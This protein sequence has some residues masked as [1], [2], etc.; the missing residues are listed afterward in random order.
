M[1]R[2]LCP[3]IEVLEDRCVPSINLVEVEPNN[4][5]MTAN[6]MQ[7][8]L[9]THQIMS[10]RIDTLGDRDWFAIQL[11]RGDV[12][13]AAVNRQS[14]LDPAVRLVNA[15][16]TTLV[17]NDNSMLGERALPPESPL[18][19]NTAD[20]HDSEIYY[21]ISATGTYY[22]EVSAS[23]D[24]ST[25]KYNLDTVVA[26]PGLESQPVGTKQ[27]LYLDFD[28]ANVNMSQFADKAPGSIK[29]APLADSMTA[30]GLTIADENAYI[31]A[32]IAQVKADLSD[33]VRANGLN[34]DYDASG[35]PGEFAIDIRNSRDNPDPFGTNPFASRIVIG[36]A[37]NFPFPTGGEAQYIDVGNF[38]TNDEAVV[39]LNFTVAA[40][41][42]APATVFDYD[43]AG[44]AHLISH[45]AG[46]IFGCFHTEQSAD[47]IF[48]GTPNLMDHFT[49]A[50]LGPDQIFGTADDINPQFGVDNYN[51][52]YSGIDDTLNTVAFGLST[53]K[54]TVAASV[55]A[56]STASA[57]TRVTSSVTFASLP[58]D[59]LLSAQP[60]SGAFP[61]PTN[62]GKLPV[63]RNP[64]AR[65]QAMKVQ[66]IVNHTMPPS[67]AEA[68]TRDFE[69]TI[70]DT[71]DVFGGSDI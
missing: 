27:I 58:Q 63:D 26:R 32:V 66:T 64:P 13:G 33:Y 71:T 55:P 20:Y 14:G 54:G 7:R 37:D 25:G 35:V 38:K 67:S 43:V 62:Q 34:G 8:V 41:I 30:L 49:L 52:P 10:G 39:P 47:D 12:F 70:T 18:P 48:A 23:G 56:N 57:V 42:Q 22:I 9:D 65:A 16:G 28:G 1:K 53:G 68:A 69:Q 51:A 31:D 36:Q 44:L 60:L 11:Q 29:F 3:T 19:I 15:A 46:H 40:P 2:T 5:P 24:A 4:M 21:V 45:E 50:I 61:T 6:V 17:A 59:Q